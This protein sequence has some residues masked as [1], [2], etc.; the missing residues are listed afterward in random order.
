MVESYSLREVAELL[1]VDY[2]TLERRVR[3][4]AFPGRFVVEGPSGPEMRVPVADVERAVTWYRTL[5]GRHVRAANPVEGG[6]CSL[7]IRKR[8]SNSNQLL[9]VRS[10]HNIEP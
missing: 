10:S 6:Y 9:R 5:L 1:G 7:I 2:A 3:E 8:T 4:G